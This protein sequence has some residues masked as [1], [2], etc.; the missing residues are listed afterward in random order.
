MS[1][2]LRIAFAANRNIGLQALRLLLEYGIE[3][4]VLVLPKSKTLDPAVNEMRRTLPHVPVLHGKVFREAEGIAQLQALDLDYFLSVHSPYII[5]QSVLDIPRVGALNLHP[6]FLPFNR[7]WHTPSWAI[8][9]QTPYG[10]TLHWVDEGTDTGD[11]ALQQRVEALAS[12]T[13]DTLYARVLA[14]EIEL[15]RE[16]IPMLESR[17]LPR[18]PQEGQGT[19]H[20]KSDLMRRRRLDL[21]QH[22][23]VRDVLRQ[24]R[25]LTTNRD[26]E[27]AYFEVDGER[28]LVQLSIR[29][30][31]SEQR[32]E[33]KVFRAA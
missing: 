32:P 17:A 9:E 31:V 24:I 15:L 5:P 13:A 8:L 1:R 29:R 18:I 4:A 10:A 23:K 12:D 3:P 26:D 16:A 27:A 2:G 20:V 21:D 28:Y 30:D 19:A 22:M 7:G 33:L 14:A 6:A 25:A 11:I